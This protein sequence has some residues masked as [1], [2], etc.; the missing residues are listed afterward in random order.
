GL[1]EVVVSAVL[2]YFV[3]ERDLALEILLVSVGEGSH[4]E[5]E[6]VAIHR[7]V[8]EGQILRLLD[9]QWPRLSEARHKVENVRQKERA[10]MV[11]VVAHEPVA[12]RRLRR[13]G[14]E[15]WMRFNHSGRRVEAGIRDAVLPDLA[16][17]VP[18]ILDEPFN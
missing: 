13:R 10:V 17:I 1:P 12:D 16:V 7:F 8:I 2:H 11:P 18:H 5:E 14:L 4:L 3:P 9:R 15:R 6:V